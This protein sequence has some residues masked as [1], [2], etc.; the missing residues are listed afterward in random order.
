MGRLHTLA[1]TIGITS[2]LDKTFLFLPPL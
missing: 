1:V 2:S